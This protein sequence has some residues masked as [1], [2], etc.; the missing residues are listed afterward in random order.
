MPIQLTGLNCML[1]GERIVGDLD[2]EFCPGCGGP[3]HTACRSPEPPAG[4]DTRCETCGVEKSR[5]AAALTR[6]RMVVAPAPPRTEP[7][8]PQVPFACMAVAAVCLEVIAISTLSGGFHF[9]TDSDGSASGASQYGGGVLFGAGL[10]AQGAVLGLLFRRSWS[11]AP[12]MAFFL[13]PLLDMC[14]RP[15]AAERHRRLNDPGGPMSFNDM[16]TVVAFI[17][18]VALFLGT[19]FKYQRGSGAPGAATKLN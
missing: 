9:L 17:G 4:A 8:R 5:V 19:W 18:L 13:L 16:L 6:P 3:R 1:C 2:A 15:T 10:L 7:Q 11:R 12:A 14:L